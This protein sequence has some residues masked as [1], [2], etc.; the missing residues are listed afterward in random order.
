MAEAIET[1]LVHAAR[2]TAAGCPEDAIAVLRPVITARPDH[3]EA[4]C[5]LAAALL[6]AGS[7]QLCLDAAKR[8]ITLGERSWAHRL[9]S[10]ALTELE[11]HD[12][13]AVS[14]R[15][16]ARRDPADWRNHVTL[17]EALGPTS[18]H[19]ALDAAERAV[20]TAPD[21]A[22]VHE[23]LGKAAAGAGD[24]PLAKNAYTDALRLDPTN[25]AV[26]AELTRLN[27]VRARRP[28]LQEGPAFGRA[29]RISLW[30]GLRRCGGWLGGGSFVLL[31]AGLPKPSPLL[32][33]FA[34]ALL[35]TV[36]AMAA[37][38]LRG[39]PREVTPKALVRREPL[40]TTGVALLL[41]GLLFLTVWTIALAL[42]ASGMQL[43][44][45]ALI[46]AAGAVGVGWYGLWRMRS[47]A[48]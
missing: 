8:A 17:A 36:V 27:G 25:T 43:L 5:R 19:E 12:E 15:E 37:V 35:V 2:L 1:A 31:I 23:V 42:G 21:E 34:L 26:R 46:V 7:P 10:L 9:A 48:R 41:L 11:R 14:A 28:A 47:F 40:L 4:W 13:A 33:W 24:Y 18:P 32:V 38:A 6:D 30:L 29:Q 39:V 20:E 22:R 44:T 3:P 16:A 45:P